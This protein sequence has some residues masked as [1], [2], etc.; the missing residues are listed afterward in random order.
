MM[1]EWASE[2]GLLCSTSKVKSWK[3]IYLATFRNISL[4]TIGLDL[5]VV[6][7]PEIMHLWDLGI[8][9]FLVMATFKGPEPRVHKT[10][11]KRQSTDKINLELGKLKVKIVSSYVPILF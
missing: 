9:Q 8:L 2:S 5:T 10:S 4:T 11:Y 1:R 7:L 3:S 6:A